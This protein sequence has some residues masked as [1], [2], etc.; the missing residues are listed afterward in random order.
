MSETR[1]VKTSI[2]CPYSFGLDAI[3][4]KKDVKLWGTEFH[5]HNDEKYCTKA[6]VVNPGGKC[7]VHWHQLKT[8]TF[9]LCAGRLVV[10]TICLS[11][12]KTTTHYLNTVGD[13]ITLLPGTPHTFYIPEDQVG[14]SWFVESS[15]QDFAND[16]YRVTQSTGPTTDNR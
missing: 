3:A 14:P 15:T 13:S 6:M 5:I 11:N 12:G 2:V 9:V 7:S 8:E 16:S 4:I 10:E 1:T